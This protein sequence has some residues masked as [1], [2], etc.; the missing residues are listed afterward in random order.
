M[1]LALLTGIFVGLIFPLL[2][3][4]QQQETRD[5]A[6]FTQ[7]KNGGNWNMIMKQ[8]EQPSVTLT[9]SNIELEKVL[10]EV[11]NQVLEIKLDKGKFKKPEIELTIVFTDLQ[12]ISTGGSGDILFLDP[13]EVENEMN[14][15][16]SGTGTLDIPGLI[17]SIL[18]INLSGSGYL[19]IHEGHVHQVRINQSGSGD[20]LA[21]NLRANEVVVKKSGSGNTALGE[22]LELTVD[23]S[24]SGDIVYQGNPRVEEIKMSGS[25]T[26]IQE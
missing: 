26:L 10:T 6:P 20:F 1:R 7:I 4:A 8:G 12:E 2:L 19:S 11:K 23:A 21:G 3:S 13:L 18:N 16:F 22:V 24:G 9:A 15:D 14:I 25:G 17:A 5:L